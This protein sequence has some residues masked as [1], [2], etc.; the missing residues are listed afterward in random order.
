MTKF[1]DYF[2]KKLNEG[3]GW[4]ISCE[5]GDWISWFKDEY[6]KSHNKPTKS[7]ELFPS[8]VHAQRVIDH[9]NMELH[10]MTKCSPKQI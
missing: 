8:K 9:E 5:D 7:E 4:A 3:A 6:T 2:S 1:K 10:F